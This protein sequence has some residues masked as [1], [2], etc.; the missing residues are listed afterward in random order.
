[1]AAPLQSKVI[2]GFTYTLHKPHK[3]VGVCQTTTP[4]LCQQ[5]AWKIVYGLHKCW[6]QNDATLYNVCVYIWPASGW[7]CVCGWAWHFIN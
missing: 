1:M 6:P 2:G 4:T 5:K 3:E 7:V